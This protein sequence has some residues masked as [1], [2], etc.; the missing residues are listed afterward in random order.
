MSQQELMPEPQSSQGEQSWSGAEIQAHISHQ[1]RRSKTSDQPKS[2]HPATFEDSLP[3]YSY[4]AQDR[5][6][7]T[8]QSSFEQSR[9]WQQQAR[10]QDTRTARGNYQ[11]YNQYNASQQIPWWAQSQGHTMDTSKWIGL[12]LLTLV[13]LVS[14]PTLCSIGT[15]FISLVFVFSILP[16]VL[17]FAPIAIFLLIPMFR[18]LGR[19]HDNHTMRYRHYQSRRN[20]WH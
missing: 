4:P 10:P 2:D 3:P 5:P 18:A 14:I 9:Q 13:V 6:T 1:S 15:V 20:Q 16:V 8:Q 11:P 17:A 19:A 12:V 7:V